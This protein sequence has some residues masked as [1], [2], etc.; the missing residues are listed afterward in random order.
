MSQKINLKTRLGRK[1][2]IAELEAFAE[3][4]IERINQRTLD[5]IT[6]NGGSFT[7]Y[8][9]SYADKKGVSR[10][11]V[12]LFLDGDMLGSLA[13]VVDPGA[14]TV[15]IFVNGDLEIKKGFNHHTGDTLPKR[16][17]F[18]VT[19]QEVNSIV[20][21]FEDQRDEAEQEGQSSRITINDLIKASNL[22]DFDVELD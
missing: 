14:G 16:P 10:D 1:P 21:D 15:E 8:S 11:S 7:P 22:I 2:T 3:I 20:A 13:H 6:V 4:A 19:T 9:E 18:G 12:D 5:G 17:W